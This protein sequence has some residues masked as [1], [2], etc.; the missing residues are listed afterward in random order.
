M[1][2]YSDSTEVAVILQNT[3][4]VLCEICLMFPFYFYSAAQYVGRVT[5][6]IGRE[7]VNP[8]YFYLPAS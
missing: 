7:Q 5:H 8:Q 1:C 3:L 2:N 6:S 4:I